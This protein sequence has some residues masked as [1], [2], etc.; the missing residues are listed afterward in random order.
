MSTARMRRCPRLVRRP[1]GALRQPDRS[2][3]QLPHR[4]PRRCLRGARRPVQGAHHQ[5]L[6][7]LPAYRLPRSRSGG[8]GDPGT[9][10][11][12]QQPARRVPADHAAGRTCGG[13]P[14]RGTGVRPRR[15]PARPGRRRRRTSNRI[16]TP[17]L[18]LVMQ[19]VWDT[20]RAEGSAELRLSTL[21]QLH[22]VKMIVD[23][24]LDK[25]LKSPEQSRTRDSHRQFDHLVTLPG[26][27]S[28]NRFPIWPSGR[29]IPKIRLTGTDEAR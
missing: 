13:G 12:L 16:S 29:A 17:L 22:G 26:A 18:Q 27:R 24:H 4:D 10:R 11:G 14:G 19:R 28:R 9:T 1:A 6:R 20:E 23:V 8:E 2:A 5:H 7:Q 3:R 25:A 21:Q 15:R